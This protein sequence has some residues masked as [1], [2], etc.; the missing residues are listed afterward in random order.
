MQDKTVFALEQDDGGEGL[1]EGRERKGGEGK[2][3]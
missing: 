3:R 1:G 2:G